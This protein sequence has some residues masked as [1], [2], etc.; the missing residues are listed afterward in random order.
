MLP[1]RDWGRAVAAVVFP[2]APECPF[3][4]QPV[5]GE[6]TGSRA[7]IC[8]MCTE[9]LAM[10]KTGLAVCPRCGK[11]RPT[12]ANTTGPAVGCADCASREPVFVQAWHIGPYTGLLRQVIHEFKYQGRQ[13]LALPLGRLMA[14]VLWAERPGPTFLNPWGELTGAVLVPIPLHPEKLRRRN[15]NQSLLLARVIA[16][17]TGFPVAEMLERCS[18]TP[19]QA[20]L[21]RR[22]RLENLQHQFAF[23][24]PDDCPSGQPPAGP[25]AVLVDD[26]YTTGATVTEAGSRLRQGGFGR[27]FVLTAATGV[28]F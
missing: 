16:A 8:A 6:V 1:W 21:S 10:A 5:G 18:D 24:P 9:L 27:V 26:V 22:E 20:G 12:S 13:R 15:F 17:E 25:V 2:Q 7:G 14:A 3:C 4:G 11:Y 19:A 28:G 23:H